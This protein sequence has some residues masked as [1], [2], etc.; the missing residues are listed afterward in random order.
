MAANSLAYEVIT[1]KILEKLEQ[2]VIPW[3]Q[4][5]STEM[6]KNV[7]SK[8]AYRGINVFLLG[9]MGYANPYWLTFRQAKQLGG[10]I[11]RGEKSTPVIFWKVYEKD[12]GEVAEDG[13]SIVKRMPVLRYYSVFNVQQCEGIPEDKIP[14]LENA[15]DFQPIEEAEKTVQGMPNPPKIEHREARA[16]YRPSVDTVNMPQTEAFTGDEEYYS[17]LFHELTHSTGHQSRLGRLDTDNLAPFGSK[18][19][20]QE[21]LVAEM[22]AAFLCGHCGI[23]DRILDNS[24]SYIAGW[25][26][27]LRSDEKLIVIAGAQAQK[28]ADFILNQGGRDHD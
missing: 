25:L 13:E 7:V 12:T 6:P 20:S 17:T 1:D 10:H 23:V 8:K 22:G 9:S 18:D 19:Y 28:A 2:G 24:A 15:R 21:E 27:R 26:G 16:F 5:W 3:R 14:A 4:P 11:R